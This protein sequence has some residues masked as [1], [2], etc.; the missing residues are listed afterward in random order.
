MFHDRI[1]E[2]RFIQLIE[3]F[4]IE[5]CFETG[6]H[7]GYGT[8]HIAKYVPN[9]ISIENTDDF[10]DKTANALFADGFKIMPGSDSREFCVFTKP[11]R[12]VNL[13]KG[14]SPTV[15]KRVLAYPVHGTCCFYLDAHWQDYWPL[16]DE[17]KEI[18]AAKIRHC[19]IIIHDCRV[20]G[21]DF[22]WDSYGGQD[23]CYDYVKEALAAI[24]PDFKISYNEA[25]DPKP[26]PYAAAIGILYA[27]P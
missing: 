23:L 8:T 14:S 9:T 24:N 13:I 26:E 2:R 10:F 18:A 21:K 20:P 19:V 6:T 25:C 5:T 7:I 12:L 17:L 22:R 1:A 11:D 27:T 16:L 4:E 3:E 15:L